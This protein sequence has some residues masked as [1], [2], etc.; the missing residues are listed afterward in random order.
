MALLQDETASVRSYA[1][2]ALGNWDYRA[3]AVPTLIALLQDETASVRFLAA[4]ALGN[5]DYRADAVP[6]LIALLQDETASVRFLAAQVLED[7]GPHPDAVP[8]LMALLQD[9]TASVRFLAAQVLGNWGRDH[10][11]VE[12]LLTHFVVEGR[13]QAMTFLLSGGE[14]PYKPCPPEA[15]TALTTI[16]RPTADDTPGDQARRQV[17]FRW[18]WNTSQSSQ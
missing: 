18:L 14:A 16:L 12:S 17:V 13:D 11:T 9:E 15:A 8:T 3:D 10:D 2:E 1:A 7:W 4:E 5:W 6:T